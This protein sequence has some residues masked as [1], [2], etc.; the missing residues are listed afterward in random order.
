MA[1]SL[2]CA[3]GKVIKASDS[4][5]GKRMPCPACGATRVVP[6]ALPPPPATSSAA[7]DDFEVLDDDTPLPEKSVRAPVKAVVVEEAAEE[8][9]PESAKKRKKKKKRRAGTDEET[10]AELYE[11]LRAND[12]RL[13]RIARGSAFLVLGL[14]IVVGVVIAFTVYPQ[15]LKEVGAR[16]IG[17]M[18]IFGLVGLAAIGKGIIGLLF[19]QF[20]GEDDGP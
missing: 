18:I 3:C 4:L 16:T 20:F 19:G 7:G 12:A 15:E 2:D 1:I 6:A 8:N 17:G 9:P 11:R 14:A 13:K 10:N 5:A